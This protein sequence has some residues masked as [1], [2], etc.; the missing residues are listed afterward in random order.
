[1]KVFI[2][3][4]I[5]TSILLLLSS[6][7]NVSASSENG[8]TGVQ[9]RKALYSGVQMDVIDIHFHPSKGWEQLGPLGREF[10]QKELPQWI[11]APL[12]TFSLKVASSLINAPYGLFGI[13]N[14]C[15]SSGIAFCGLFATYAPETWGVVDNDYISEILADDRNSPGS[16]GKPIFF[17]LAS[18][19]INN[20]EE[21]K[22]EKLRDLEA[23][24]ANTLFKGIKMAHIHNNVP[25]SMAGYDGIYEI[26]RKYALPVYH[27]IGSTPI[28]S[29]DDFDTEAE[30]LHYVKSYDPEEL[31]F[32]IQSYPDVTFIL[33][34]MGF[35]FNKE[36][37]DFTDESIAMAKSYDNV[38]LEISALGRPAFD[39]DGK[40]LD[41]AFA[42]FAAEGIV[43]KIIYGS[44]GPVYPG[45]TKAYLNSVL[46]SME[47]NDYS[48]LDA[49]KV[50]FHNANN[51]FRI[52]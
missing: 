47:R 29:L 15:T 5:L 36:G 7:Q 34:H 8:A 48:Y 1:M 52:Y 44:D 20:W 16:L 12:K 41:Y 37:Y 35:D 33:G 4:T 18:I 46:R 2:A 9:N 50:L 51:I 42:R 26:A 27:H 14:E 3:L 10:I 28:R 19:D 39:E 23:T 49:Q 32:L 40:F 6:G 30:K 43:E 22:K 21:T 31:D 11:P 38:Y 24:V 17:G 25:L 13:K 45:A